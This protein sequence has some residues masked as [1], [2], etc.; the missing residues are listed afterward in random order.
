[1]GGG[2]SMG[3]RSMIAPL[4]QK[5]AVSLLKLGD[6]KTRTATVELAKAASRKETQL[7]S[8]LVLSIAL[9]PQDKWPEA[10]QKMETFLA[11]VGVTK[12]MIDQ[13]ALPPLDYGLQIEGLRA[14]YTLPL[15][16]VEKMA[17][18]SWDAANPAVRLTQKRA[19]G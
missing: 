19:I 17:G 5:A 16:Q 4:P 1:M 15:A 9:D 3:G 2:S 13:A 8:E 6:K 12:D 14:E 10:F 7:E 11:G 18:M